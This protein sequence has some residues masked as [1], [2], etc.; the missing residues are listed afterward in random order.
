MIGPAISVVLPVYNGVADV[1]KAVESVLA[2]TFTEFELI[3]INDGSKDQ[4]A[5]VLEGIHDSRIRLFHQDNAGLA[6]TLNRGIEMARGRYIARQ[7][8]DDLS[9]PQRFEK[10]FV[11]M[12]A[13]PK[14]GLLG[15]RADI[16]VG[17]APSGRAHEHPS[18]HTT[19]RF[20]LLF[21]NPF[22]HSSVMLRRNVLIEIGGYTTDP[23]RQP[24]EDYE[25]WSRIAR[26][27]EV[28]NL[29]EHLLVYREVSASMSRT[30]TNPFVEKLVLICAENIAAVLGAAKPSR[31]VLDVAAYTHSAFHLLSDSPNIGRMCEIVRQAGHI[32]E[33]ISPGSNIAALAESRLVHLRHQ[34]LVNQH[35]ADWVRPIVRFY[36]AIRSRLKSWVRQV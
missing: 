20:E 16:W 4:S 7:D 31:D 9:L 13:N 11:Y 28:A 17:D 15:T 23:S 34:Y 32:L 26:Y 3:I 22:V 8:Q 14:C 5:S 24:P 1:K 33:E 25:L 35:D 27:C 2:Q 21:N 10:Q 18:D 6:A 19:L 36:R 12:E 30:G 29:P